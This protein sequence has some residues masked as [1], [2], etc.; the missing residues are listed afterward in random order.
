MAVDG[1]L[2]TKIGMTQIFRENGKLVGVTAVQAGPCAVTQIRVPERDNYSAVQI[3]FSETRNLKSPE[4]GHLKSVGK[5]F[6][7]LQGPWFRWYCEAARVCWRSQD[8]RS[9]R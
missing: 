4:R 5:L 8:P 9:I 2:G 1:I 6:R 3:G 7:H